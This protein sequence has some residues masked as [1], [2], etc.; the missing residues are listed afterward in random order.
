M[1][2]ILFHT[3]LSLYTYIIWRISF[4]FTWKQHWRRGAEKKRYDNNPIL[5][6]L[7]PVSCPCFFFASHSHIYWRSSCVKCFTHHFKKNYWFH[8][9][10][11]LFLFLYYFPNKH[12]H[13]WIRDNYSRFP[14]FSSCF[15]VLSFIWLKYIQIALKKISCFF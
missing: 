2:F 11:S 14:F 3:F 10:T 8:I 7:Q 4:S 9:Y 15:I 5:F 12:S 6:L 13:S 1:V